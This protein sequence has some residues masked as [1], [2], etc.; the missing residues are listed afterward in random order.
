MIAPAQ[1]SVDTVRAWLDTAGFAN[2]SLST[3]KQWLQFDADVKAVE[4][5]LSAEYHVFEHTSTGASNVACNEY[6]RYEPPSTRH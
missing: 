5:L 4:D 1:Q 2:V 6:A 3:N